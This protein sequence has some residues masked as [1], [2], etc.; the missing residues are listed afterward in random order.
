MADAWRVTADDLRDVATALRYEQDGARLRR[1]LAGELRTAVA[2]AV[3]EAKGRIMAM[4]SHGLPHK[5]EPLRAAVARRVTVQVR[6]T[7]RAA[8]VRVRVP[9]KGMPRG[10]VNAPRRLNRAK[11]RHPVFGDRDRWVTQVGAP[12]WFDD[13][14][15]ARRADYRRAVEQVIGD[16]ADRIREGAG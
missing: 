13:P 3:A 1:G 9:K 15:R 2:P 8:G 5:G 14:L 7:G 4:G 11:W 12:G 10:F 6:L 16:L